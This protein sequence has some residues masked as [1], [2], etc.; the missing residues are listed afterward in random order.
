MNQAQKLQKLVDQIERLEGGRVVRV[1]QSY[2]VYGE[3]FFALYFQTFA[4]GECWLQRWIETGRQPSLAD[5]RV[6]VRAS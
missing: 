1:R 5:L 2:Y 3:H 4:K 6:G